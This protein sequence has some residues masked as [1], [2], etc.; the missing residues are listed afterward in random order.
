MVDELGYEILFQNRTESVATTS[1][2]SNPKV[3]TFDK[4]FYQT[5]NL[6]ITA[7]NMATGDYYVISSQSRTGFSITFFNSSNSAIDRAFAYHA[8]GFGAEGA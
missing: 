3:I 6:G 8:N 5:P 1:G 7:S 2:G 4:A